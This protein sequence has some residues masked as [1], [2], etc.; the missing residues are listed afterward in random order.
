MA[1]RITKL[2]QTEDVFDVTVNGNQNFYAN[3]VLVHNCEINLVTKALQRNDD[4][5]MHKPIRV[6]VDKVE[7]FKAYKAK[8]RNVLYRDKLRSDSPDDWIYEED[9]GSPKS[10]AFEY[11]TELLRDK[12]GASIAL[13]TL[14]AVNWGNIK[15]PSDF[16][17]PCTLLVRALDELLDLQ[18]YPVPAAQYATEEFR[19]LG[20]GIINLAYFLAKNDTS[21]SDPNA[22]A[23]I[24][25]Y[26]EAW[27]YYLIKA[28]ADLAIEKGPCRRWKDLKYADGILPIDTRKMDIDQLV[29]HIE[30]MPWN[31]LREQI[32]KHGI[33]NATL[34]ALMP[35]ECQSLN[36]EIK[37]KDG[38]KI[39]LEE[40]IKTHCLI[41]PDDVHEQQMVGQRFEFIKPL[42]LYDS[43]AYEC[44]YNG[45]QPVTEIEFEDGNKYRFTENHVLFVMR[46]GSELEVF[47]K[48]LQEGDE[49]V[50]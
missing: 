37:L 8:S 49:I 44:Y 14:S 38:S 2:E 6:P 32:K 10:D 35:S 22:L 7:G 31:E 26:A 43:V 40:V 42:E 16:E 27:S 11:S 45:V 4:G 12:N 48:D 18:D 36:N 17:K 41:N 5:A 23:L 46:G 28:S 1:L 29:P 24:D 33:R 19:P 47:V 9:D 50:V 15:S 39:S 3:D 20:I 34:M 30:R 21:Y 25:E 13:C